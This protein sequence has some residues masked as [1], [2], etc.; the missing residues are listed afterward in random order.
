MLQARA[1]E[2]GCSSPRSL[3][4]G[5]SAGPETV[6]VYASVGVTTRD[7]YAK[8]LNYYPKRTDLPEREL[9]GRSTERG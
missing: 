6:A 4:A 7:L 2:A 3:K 8:E 1:V 9:T 5:P